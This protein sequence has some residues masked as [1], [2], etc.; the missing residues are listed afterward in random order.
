MP[1]PLCPCRTVDISAA[2]RCPTADFRGAPWP[3]LP[4]PQIFAAARGPFCRYR[5]HFA[6]TRFSPTADIS[7]AARFAPRQTFLQRAVLPLP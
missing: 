5:R 3:V 4:V 6:A 7:G 2:T 1:A